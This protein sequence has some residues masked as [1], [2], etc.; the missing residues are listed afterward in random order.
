VVLAFALGQPGQ[1]WC[2]VGHV[3]CGQHRIELFDVRTPLVI[4][5]SER[6]AG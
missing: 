2:I 4:A 3:E 1:S 6:R 5:A